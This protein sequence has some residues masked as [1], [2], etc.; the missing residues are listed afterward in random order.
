MGFPIVQDCFVA[1]RGT[2]LGGLA[3]AVSA[4]RPPGN[5]GRTT[6]HA[7]G[8]PGG[9]R[10][11]ARRETLRARWNFTRA[12]FV[13]H[14]H[15]GALRF[16]IAARRADGMARRMAACEACGVASSGQRKWRNASSA[17]ARS[18]TIAMNARVMAAGSPCWMT[19]RP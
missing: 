5:T 10:Q 8:H 9:C 18:C 11:D 2:D 3:T 1:E 16:A 13:R 7:A 17:V 14:A 6:Q 12:I 19:L 15:E 4:A